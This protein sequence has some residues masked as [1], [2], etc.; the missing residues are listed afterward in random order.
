VRFFETWEEVGARVAEAREALGVTQARLASQIG[1]DRTALAKIERGT[2]GLSS[3]ELARLATA[4]QRPIEWFIREAPPA[5]VSRRQALIESPTST[6]LDE[7]LERAARDIELVVELRGLFD[8]EPRRPRALKSF[9]DAEALAA[10]VRRDIAV[11]DGPLTDLGTAVE[12]MGLHAFVFALE[13]A[14]D[15]AYAA[16]GNV[17]VTVV[18]GSMQ[19]G[20]RRFTL[21][22]ELGHHLLSDAYSTDYLDEA[23]ATIEGLIN[24]FAAYLLMPRHSV[25]AFWR[26]RNGGRDPRAAAIQLAA[27]YRVSWTAACSHLHNLGLV[28]DRT[29]TALTADPPRRIDYLELGWAFVEELAPPWLAPGYVS[30]VMRLYRRH[31]ISAERALALLYGTLV[32][33]DLP[34]QHEIPLDG[35]RPDVSADQ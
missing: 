5:V 21:A 13:Q 18:N 6:S 2:R 25:A 33:G 9:N 20:R 34:G 27:L 19:S 7:L 26:D 16:V 28:D 35:L 32:N 14:A 31:K 10:E 22:H 11:P 4:L 17:G 30:A 8:A 29:R 15:G 12:R 1:L 24:A 3:L 23:G